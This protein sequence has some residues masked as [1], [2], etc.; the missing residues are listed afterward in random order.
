[1]TRDEG[2]AE[3]DRRANELLDR[4]ER[5]RLEAELDESAGRDY[6]VA[7][8]SA[9]VGAIPLVGQLLG[10]VISE[11]IPRRRQERMVEFARALNR[12]VARIEPR[13]DRD[14]VQTDDLSDLVEEVLERISRRE[15]DGKRA[16][17]AAAL[18]NTLT[19]D[20]PEA[21]EL[22]RMLD[23]LDEVRPAHL[24]LLAAIA[25][26]HGHPPGL[27]GSMSIAPIVNAVLPN[28]PEEQWR[29]D[30]RELEQLGVLP[31][32]P[33]GMMTAQG[34]RNLAA[35]ITDFGR[36]FLAWISMDEEAAE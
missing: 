33:G 36:R 4:E 19:T 35:R 21:D 11:H 2:R 20:R 17:Y 5:D 16:Y 25:R 18:A 3:I 13:L 28:T 14:F 22:E 8:G 24:R 10:T 1:M 9:A 26:T 27:E 23:V 30:W 12:A 32:F 29:M 31:S 7:L 34:T 6:V 15:S